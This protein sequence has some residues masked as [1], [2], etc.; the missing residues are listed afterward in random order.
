[1]RCSARTVQIGPVFLFD[2]NKISWNSI[3][4]KIEKDINLRIET[5]RF[6]K[7]KTMHQNI[8]GVSV[9]FFLH[10]K[11][12]YM[13]LFSVLLL[14]FFANRGTKTRVGDS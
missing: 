12:K 9:L 3:V 8:G 13:E 14:L 7:L 2:L 6:A 10:K 5:N 1:M 11:E 4:S